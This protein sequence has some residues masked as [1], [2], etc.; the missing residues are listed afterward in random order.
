MVKGAKGAVRKAEPRDETTPSFTDIHVNH[1]TCDG[2]AR[3][4]YLSGLPELPLADVTLENIRIDHAGTGIMIE[5]CDRITLNHVRVNA[6]PGQ[7]LEKRENV[8]HLVLDD[9]EATN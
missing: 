6:R 7:L 3:A 1:L 2:C 4:I 5:D 8:D 9:V